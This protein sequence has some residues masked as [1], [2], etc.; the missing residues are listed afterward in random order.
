MKTGFEMN[1]LNPEDQLSLPHQIM[2]SLE[3][4]KSGLIQRNEF[5]DAVKNVLDPDGRSD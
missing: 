4:S 5:E 3:N 1:L 2:K